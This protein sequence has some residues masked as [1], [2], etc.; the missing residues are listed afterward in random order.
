MTTVVEPIRTEG[1]TPNGG[2]YAIARFTRDGAPAPKEQ[3]DAVEV[4]EYDAAGREIHRT[5]AR[6]G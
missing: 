2:A 1:P 6:I 4:V 3:A 5:Y